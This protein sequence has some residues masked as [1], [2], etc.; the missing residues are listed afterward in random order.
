MSFL[1]IPC[2]TLAGQQSPLSVG[3]LVQIFESGGD[4]PGWGEFDIP[5]FVAAAYGQRAR[6]AAIWILTQPSSAQNYNHQLEALTLGQYDRVDIPT[7]ILVDYAMAHGQA[8]GVLR[9]RAISSLSMRPDSN[10][11]AFWLQIMSDS[12]GSIRQ[13]APAG[14]SCAKGAAAMADIRRLLVDTNSLVVSVAAFY[15]REL[16]IA[17]TAGRACGG[18]YTRTEA[19]IVPATLRPTLRV[20][21]AALLRR[22][23]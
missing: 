3:Q 21:G 4:V 11:V 22:I 9:Q 17:D 16:S 7:S 23:P 6:N 18:R 12:D 19:R 2:R 5:E 10:L 14:L 20:R 1:T 13:F 8:G 15:V